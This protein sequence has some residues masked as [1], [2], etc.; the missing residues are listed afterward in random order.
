MITRITIISGKSDN[1]PVAKVTPETFFVAHPL[2][3]R[4]IENMGP[5]NS[6]EIEHLPYSLWLSGARKGVPVAVCGSCKSSFDVAWHLHRRKELPEWGSV[7]ALEQATGRGQVRREWISPPGNIYAVLKWPELPKSEEGEGRPIWSR[8]LPLVVGDLVCK[9]LLSFGA[10]VSLK[11]PN[12]LLIGNQKVGGILIEER[13]GATMVGIGLNLASAPDKSLLRKD[14]I[15]ATQINSGELQLSPLETWA[16]I[17]SFLKGAFAETIANLEPSIFLEKLANKLVWFG[18]E[19]RI[20]DGPKGL[21]KG[22]ITGLMEDGGLIVEQ[23][24]EKISVYSGSV[25]PIDD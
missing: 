15:S 25:M 19:V 7:L 16:E 9:A 8:I 1:S 3:A 5:W 24:G 20:V 6:E 10:E 18:Q 2:W 22:V 13:D 4:D 17:V 14:S 21:E 12:D 23:D 11:W